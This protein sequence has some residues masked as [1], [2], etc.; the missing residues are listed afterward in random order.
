MLRLYVLT[1]KFFEGNRWRHIVNDVLRTLTHR[2]S[3]RWA[4]RVALIALV[5]LPAA[6]A[7]VGSME[8]FEIS[9]RVTAGSGKHTIF[10]ALWSSQGFLDKPVEQ[11]RIDPAARPVFHFSVPAGSWAV[12]AFE[13]ENNNGVLDMGRFGPRE[14]SGFWRPFHGWRKPRFRDVEIFVDHNIPDANVTLRR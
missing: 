1:N 7:Q 11:V 8:R 12:S 3:F 9:G 13:D 6:L 10:V 5:T 14:P 2:S 4:A